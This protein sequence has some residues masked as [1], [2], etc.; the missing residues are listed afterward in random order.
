MPRVDFLALD[1]DELAALTNRG[2]VKRAI[3]EL[4]AGDLEYSIEETDASLVVIWSDGITCTFPADAA[5]QD[6]I[7]SSGVLGISRHQIRSILAYQQAGKNT[8]DNLQ[9][10]E[11]QTEDLQ[12]EDQLPVDGRTEAQLSAWDPGQITDQQLQ[13][14]FGKAAITRARKRYAEGVLAEVRHGKKP[15]VKFLHDSCS[16]RFPVPHDLRYATG[17]CEPRQLSNWVPQAV[18]AF[19]ELAVDQLSGLVVTN[20]R[21]IE[22]PQPT[23]K[24]LKKLLAELCQFGVANLPTTWSQQL[25]R[26]EGKLKTAKL[27]WPASLCEA[28]GLQVQSYRDQDARFDSV[29]I[30]R[31]VGESHARVAVMENL[32]SPIPHALVAGPQTNRET[33]L[34]MARLV[35]VGLDANPTAT[36]VQFRIY[37]QDS[38]TGSVLVL[39]RSLVSR[40]NTKETAK[41][42]DELGS[43][44]IADQFSIETLARS[45]VLLGSGKRRP[46]DELVLPRGRG[47]LSVNAQAFLWEKLLPPF[48][49][50]SFE[51]IK[52]RLQ[53]LPPE[54]LRPRR[55]AEDLHVVHIERIEDA[56]FDIRTQRLVATLKDSEG[57]AA[58]LFFSYHSQ[59]RA[60]FERLLEATVSRGDQAKFICGH[61]R[62]ENREPVISPISI[63]FESKGQRDMLVPSLAG[64]I[65]T[66]ETQFLSSEIDDTHN[67][68][69]EFLDQ[70]SNRVGDAMILGCENQP[71]FEWES[72][73]KQGQAIGFSKMLQPIRR[74]VDNLKLNREQLDSHAASS[75]NALTKLCVYLRLLGN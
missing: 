10:K 31:L 46:S 26:V 56:F 41:S 13:E 33:A 40:E 42:F 38:E 58:K 35:A 29:E 70:M 39:K 64:S 32:S 47:K 53:R 8:S 12:K 19:R 74:L 3:R 5:I 71:S 69:S 62:L 9:T 61:L 66:T 52:Q 24:H 45:L 20:D 16:I 54:W 36:S 50:E 27:T 37:F 28:I 49:A 73:L 6:A 22:L 30:S 59:G 55:G 7:C 2:T 1:V 72:L 25:T 14:H 34:K 44:L 17:D 11:L 4:E 68:I 65:E 21:S 15:T 48:A 43:R 67:P 23:I 18:W 60:G 63:V 75:A 51:Q 57:G